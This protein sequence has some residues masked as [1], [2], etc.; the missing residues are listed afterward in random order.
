MGVLSG[1]L[2]GIQTQP[3]TLGFGL[4]QSRDDL[5]NVGYATVY[6]LAMIAKLVLAQLLLVWL[7]T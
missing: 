4:E 2:A 3:A 6:P 7:G 1:V 5:P